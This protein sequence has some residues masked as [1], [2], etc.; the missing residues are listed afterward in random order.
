MNSRKQVDENVVKQ[1]TMKAGVKTL[2]HLI[3]ILT[4]CVLNIQK[5]ILYN[6]IEFNLPYFLFQD[7]AT[8][9]RC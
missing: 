4:Q 1:E 6:P 2:R 8:I 5:D 3:K 7:G 9:P